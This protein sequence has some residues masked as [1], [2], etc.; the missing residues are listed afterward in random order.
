MLP[1]NYVICED[2]RTT[3][4]TAVARV[5]E[6]L[7]RNKNGRL[8]E[9]AESVLLELYRVQAR[10]SCHGMPRLSPSGQFYLVGPQ[11]LLCAVNIQH[12]CTRHGCSIQYNIATFQEREKS[13]E[14]KGGVVHQGD[15]S[16][17]VL[18]TAQMRDGKYVQKYRMAS[19]PLQLE[20]ILDESSAREW[21]KENS[22]AAPVLSNPSS[23]RPSVVPST[24]SMAL[25]LPRPMSQAARPAPHLSNLNPDRPSTPPLHAQ[26]SYPAA[27]QPSPS[28][29]S[30]QPNAWSAPQ[31]GPSSPSAIWHSDSMQAQPP[32]SNP[33]PPV[34]AQA[35]RSVPEAMLYYRPGPKPISHQRSQYP[36]VDPSPLQSTMPYSPPPYPVAPSPTPSFHYEPF[37]LVTRAAFKAYKLKFPGFTLEDLIDAEGIVKGAMEGVEVLDEDVEL[38]TEEEA[39]NYQALSPTD[40]DQSPSFPA[41][42]LTA[43]PL[44]ILAKKA[45]H[46]QQNR[47]EKA[48]QHEEANEVRPRSVQHAQ[49]A[50]P[51]H[52]SEFDAQKLPIAS[53]GWT[54][55][56][57]GGKLSPTFQRL[58]RHL[59]LL[60]Q[61]GLQLLDWD[62]RSCI[63]LIDRK[64][65]I[66]G[67]PP[68]ANKE[69][70]NWDTSMRNLN[71]AVRTCEQRSTFAAKE[72]IHPWGHFTACAAGISYGG[73]REAPGNIRISGQVNQAEMKTLLEHPDMS[74]LVGFTNSFAA[75]TVNFGPQTVTPPHLDA[76]NLGHGWCTDTALGDYDPDK[77]GASGPMESEA[78]HPVSTWIYCSFS[79]SPYYPFQYS[80]TGA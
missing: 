15:P 7:M 65:R 55:N 11:S 43:S 39:Q 33:Y 5:S 57:K 48:C 35:P 50:C 69:G 45:T 71:D 64:D 70:G 12:D 24:S 51:S 23:V 17:L 4:A 76:G 21:R 34:Q 28:P 10:A 29:F 44:P 74:R 14:M 20:R 58:W 68:S 52:L 31:A 41:I 60:T 47:I 80:H 53:M 13:S 27:Q 40:A 63:V 56:R 30:L 79:V 1:G 77:G 78:C 8:N 62:G 19:Q 38:E 67:V 18:N 61:E 75:T 26:A 49:E 46:D 6:I 42:I 72:E 54:G 66:V 37:L 3:D 9:A 73:G 2:P 59:S 36:T 16:D 32:F 22:L 25:R